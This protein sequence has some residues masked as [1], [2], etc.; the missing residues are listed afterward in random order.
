MKKI[1]LCTVICLFLFTIFSGC[2]SETSEPEPTVYS[3]T[4]SES[5]QTFSL[6]DSLSVTIP[7]GL[8][9]G[10]DT[11]SLGF[12]NRTLPETIDTEIETFAVYNISLNEHSELSDSIV[13]EFSYD[14]SLLDQS[15]P[16][17]KGFGVSYWDETLEMWLTV[18]NTVD[19]ENNKITV[20]TNHLSTWAVWRVQGYKYIVTDEGNFNVY[21][22]PSAYPPILDSEPGLT[23]EQLAI[24]IGGYLE[25]CYK[26]Y[27]D[28]GFKVPTTYITRI[29]TMLTNMVNEG[30]WSGV[31]GWI[32]LPLTQMTSNSEI[33]HDAG[34]ELFHYVQNQYASVY[35]AAGRMWWLE[36][37]PDYASGVLCWDTT[38]TLPHFDDM[39]QRLEESFFSEAKAEAY[40]VSRFIQW[41][42]GFHGA[43]FKE[44]WDFVEGNASI[45]AISTR[46][47]FQEYVTDLTDKIFSSTFEDY[48]VYTLFDS[49]SPFSDSGLSQLASMSKPRVLGKANSSGE[50]IIEYTESFSLK[51]GYTATIWRITCEKPEK[52]D[53]RTIEI[54]TNGVPADCSV[55]IYKL[56]NNTKGSGNYNLLK[57]FVGSD[58][59]KVLLNDS[60][61]IYAVMFN[62]GESHQTVTLTAEAEEEE[63][64]N[65]CAVSADCNTES[66]ELEIENWYLTNAFNMVI[67]SSGDLD[68]P[69]EAYGSIEDL[70]DAYGV[71]VGKEIYI[72][73]TSS[74][75][76]NIAL[77]GTY[78]TTIT[79]NVEGEGSV[80][81]DEGSSWSHQKGGY[82]FDNS[83]YNF[84][85]IVTNKFN[86]S[87]S[88][89]ETGT[90]SLCLSANSEANYEIYFAF[91]Y[92]QDT[93]S[94][95]AINNDWIL[96]ESESG[97]SQTLIVHIYTSVW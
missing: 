33:S 17:D 88:T 73:T 32:Y 49:G 20:E 41:M 68:T 78:D 58:T 21:Y 31:T 97:T 85:T 8:L 11:L 84:R 13:L 12:S 82:R 87:D 47:T 80:P 60:D 94:F 56:L 59:T 91:D 7:G 86:W 50:P 67:A 30:E 89:Q 35:R 63:E 25:H 26:R 48:A 22:K 64:E 57:V 24:R 10:A 14:E 44:M 74:M 55:M 72:M 28:A 9:D 40:Y 34:H 23:M 15:I 27:S 1:M 51:P 75:N 81:G 69:A 77:S 5:D 66:F 19:T 16:E 4:P 76:E 70:T 95:D 29:N 36:G 65:D 18:E 92:K 90:Y 43:D 52:G 93:Y 53:T 3:V 83:I 38:D 6:E 61:A 71:V 45:A 62:S 2:Q 42:I 54:S 96:E 79:L 39:P 37:T 46:Y